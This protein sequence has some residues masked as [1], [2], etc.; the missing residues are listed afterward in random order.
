MRGQI[1]ARA[2]IGAGGGGMPANLRRRCTTPGCPKLTDQSGRC[3]HC[4]R[5]KMR[6]KRNRS[7]EVH[8]YGPRWPARRLNYLIEH[9]TCVY[10]G[11]LSA[12]PDHWPV[13]RR[14]LV[15]DGVLDPD[16]DQYL[17][18]LCKACH[19][20]ETGRNQPGGWHRDRR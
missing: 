18:P 2:P 14:Q 6:L 3:A 7:R 15:A 10:C 19:D 8:D 20:R 11:R 1:R 13:S 9:P 16:A 12:V 4:R 5:G 17:R